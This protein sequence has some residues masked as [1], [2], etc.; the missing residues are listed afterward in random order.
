MTDSS[1]QVDASY[2]PPS[3]PPSNHGHTLAAWFTTIV[4]VVGSV[5]AGVAMCVSANWL[6]WVGAAIVV[7]GL[8]G[9]KVLS[10]AGYGQS[11]GDSNAATSH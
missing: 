1:A 3:A 9:G 10:V 4:V 6:I 7:V 2:L 8:V 5:L 11:A